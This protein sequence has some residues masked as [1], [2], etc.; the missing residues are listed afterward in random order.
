MRTTATPTHHKPYPCSPRAQVGLAVCRYPAA[1]GQ[2]GRTSGDMSPRRRPTWWPCATSG[3]S[4]CSP[5]ARCHPERGGNGREHTD[6][7]LEYELPGFLVFHGRYRFFRLMIG[8]SRPAVPP[9]H[10]GQRGGRRVRE[11]QADSPR[12]GLTPWARSQHRG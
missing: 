11:P 4:L 8:G 3:H 2:R 12:T 10:T 7:H 1:G 5:H 9:C 6:D